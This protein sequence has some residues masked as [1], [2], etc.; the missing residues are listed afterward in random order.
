MIP[1]TK[2]EIGAEERALV[3]DVLD[4]GHLAQGPLVERFEG[5][6]ASMAESEHAIAVNNGT[7][8]LVLA[9]EALGIRPGDEVITSPLTFVATVNAILEAGATVRF[10]DVGDDYNLDPASIE[11][12]INDR[13][14]AV[15]PVHL[16][17][18]AAD[19]PAIVSIAERRGLAVIEDA[20]QAHF[21]TTA[22]GRAVGSHGLGCF[23]FYATKNIMCGEGGVVTTSDAALA[24][25]MRILRNQGMR[26]RYE[27]E[28]AGH[29]YRLTDLAAAVAI[30]QFDR[31]DAAIAARRAN[32]A[33]LTEGLD[34]VRGLIPPRAE[35]GRGHVWHQYTVRLTDEASVDRDGL[36]DSL[37]E[38]EIGHGI[39]YPRA[40]YDYECYRSHPG[41]VIDGS[42][43]AESYAR[44]ILSL[45][46]H[47][48]L[49]DDEV[50]TVIEVV[51]EALG[52]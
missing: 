20:A 10:G 52:A 16:Y 32:A 46:V 15:M 29:N 1:I 3:L 50:D 30:P 39:Y 44:S 49:L 13:T 14:R 11:A 28:V 18:Q 4:R 19:M 5:L 26:A 37:V 42:P 35:S 34:D 12:L 41:V 25:R 9:I 2:I 45:P 22:E 31:V 43:R 40:V 21:A 51:R 33:R 7:T 36:I 47:Q 27:Y 17:G 48:H 6:C 8:A 24:D 23:S 38:N